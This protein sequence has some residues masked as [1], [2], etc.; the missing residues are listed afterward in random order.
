[1]IDILTS[2]IVGNNFRPAEARYRYGKLEDGEQLV[3]VREPSNPYD[4]NAIQIHTLDGI[5]LGFIPKAKN[6]SLAKQMDD[7]LEVIAHWDENAERIDIK[8]LEE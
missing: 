2:P 4:S 8:V 6:Q 5:F 1:M 3:L 7:G